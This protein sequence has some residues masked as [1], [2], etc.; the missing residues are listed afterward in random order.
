MAGP[1]PGTQPAAE[2]FDDGAAELGAEEEYSDATESE[3]ELRDAEAGEDD[4]AGGGEDADAGGDEVE[5]E[6]PVTPRRRPRRPAYD[7]ENT[8]A[9][10]RAEREAAEA[11]TQ[12][13]MTTQLRNEQTQ[14]EAEA[15]ERARVELMTAD[16]KI[17]YYAERNERRSAA[18]LN[19]ALF[20]MQDANDKTSFESFCDRNPQ[21]ARLASVVEKRL[22]QLRAT[23]QNV[24]RRVMMRQIL[25]ERAEAALERP[26]KK[27]VA[28]AA[29]ARQRE[30]GRGAAPP[31]GHSG[32][33]VRRQGGV[34][35]RTAR[36]RRLENVPI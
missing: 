32:V 33:A 30:Y 24:P 3:D 8:E 27:A 19:T 31:A 22:M 6:E 25:G 26:S 7:R 9:R 35:E 36:R 2:D 29:Q 15:Q 23:G 1:K 34:D 10:I 5:I 14:R 16:E 18:Q 4:E 28:K 12:L 13:R 21:A 17:Q 11:Q 20:Q